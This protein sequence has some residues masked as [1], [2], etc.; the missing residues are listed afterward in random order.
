MM[1]TLKLILLMVCTSLCMAPWQSVYAQDQ[2]NNNTRGGKQQCRREDER[3]GW[4]CTRYNPD[5]TDTSTE[6]TWCHSTPGFVG[7]ESRNNRPITCLPRGDQPPYL[8]GRAAPPEGP[9]LGHVPPTG[10]IPPRGPCAYPRNQVTCQLPETPEYKAALKEWMDQSPYNDPSNFKFKPKPPPTTYTWKDDRPG[11]NVDTGGGD[12]RAY[13]FPNGHVYEFA[14]NVGGESGGFLQTSP[15]PKEQTQ[16]GYER[17]GD[18]PY[19]DRN[20]II[21]SYTGTRVK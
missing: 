10:Q 11:W 13:R 6:P 1:R 8:K 15:P 3:D 14:R 17:L 19:K 7:P 21:R 16:K 18:A 2:F 9:Y 20:N 12:F 4:E 5:L